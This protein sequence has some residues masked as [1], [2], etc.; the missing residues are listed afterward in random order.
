MSEPTPAPA[1]L[2]VLAPVAGTVIAVADI[3]DPVFSAALVGPGAAIAPDPVAGRVAV[4]PIA[5]V[6]VKLHPHAFVVAADDGRAVLVHLGIDTVELHGD[7]FELHVAEG[8]RVAAGQPVVGWDPAAVRAGGR[9]PV[10]PVVALDAEESELTG[11]AAVGTTLTTSD[12]L[13]AIA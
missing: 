12:V 7:G 11:L 6:V 5:G 2:A 13:F 3:P 10:V 1:A 9:S 4:A 8:D